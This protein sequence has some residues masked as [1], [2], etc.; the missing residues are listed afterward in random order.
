MT[1]ERN[2]HTR[3]TAVFPGLPGW[4]DARRNLLDFY[5]AWEDNRGRH[6]DYPDGRHSIQTNP[7][8]HFR[9]TSIFSSDAVPA[10]ALPL[11]RG[12]GQAPNMVACVPSGVV[13]QRQKPDSRP[14]STGS[15][16]KTA[17]NMEVGG[18]SMVFDS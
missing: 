6:T 2:T 12:L 11:Y 16:V 8:T 15:P 14:V 9:N 3:F 1:R 7:T 13:D 17:V 4:A 5:G 10:I 18:S